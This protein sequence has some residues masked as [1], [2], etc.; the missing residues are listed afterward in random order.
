M[1]EK[2][3]ILEREILLK[4]S[5][6]S[7]RYGPVDLQ[8]TAE[9]E[10]G[11]FFPTIIIKSAPDGVLRGLADDERI[12]SMDLDDGELVILPAPEEFAPMLSDGTDQWDRLER[13]IVE[14]GVPVEQ[15][16]EAMKRHSDR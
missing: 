16:I 5:A 14:T 4:I 9:D 6:L 1:N 12:A 15:I 13:A 3:G 11:G 7:L 2:Y 10:D 8:I